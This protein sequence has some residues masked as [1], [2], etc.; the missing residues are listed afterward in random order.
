MF[1]V[2]AGGSG[3]GGCGAGSVKQQQARKVRKKQ[4]VLVFDVF[5]VVSGVFIVVAVAGS[6]NYWLF[7]H[8]A[9]Y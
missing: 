6:V 2:V 1:F 4:T 7:L 8:A 3:G 9:V 5:F